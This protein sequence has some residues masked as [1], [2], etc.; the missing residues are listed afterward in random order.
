MQETGVGFFL[1]RNGKRLWKSNN[2]YAS[3]IVKRL[4]FLYNIVMKCDELEPNAYLTINEVSKLL[5][6]HP[7]TLRN[8]D[9]N[10]VL[11][12]TRIGIKKVRR[13]RKSDIDRFIT[14][15]NEERSQNG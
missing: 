4:C 14:K 6:V 5:K 2:F 15:S 8:W 7:N 11:V 13:Y 12:A 3:Y 10:G 9:A 1:T